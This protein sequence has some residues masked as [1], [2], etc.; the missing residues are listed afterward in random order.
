[1]SSGPV[2]GT[3]RLEDA[4]LRTVRY[5]Y[6]AQA[7]GPADF[8]YWYDKIPVKEIILSEPGLPGT[9]LRLPMVHGPGDPFHRLRAYVKR[10]VDK[11]PAILLDEQMAR[12]RCARGEVENVAAA[13]TLAVVDAGA[14]GRVY[15]VAEGTARTEAEWAVKIGHVLGWQGR[16]VPIPRDRIPTRYR[17]EQSLDTDTRQIRQELGYAEP[18]TPGEALRRTIVWERDHSA[19][20]A[21]GLGL[22][23]E[24]T[25]DALMAELG[26]E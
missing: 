8:R 26:L 22:L 1:M 20:Q 13:I 18:V 14:A 4:P 6:R 2:E 21:G 9:V 3:P 11:R 16:V 17:W 23:D 15:N 10:M 24:A 25:E 19:Q 5:P 7:E 12:W